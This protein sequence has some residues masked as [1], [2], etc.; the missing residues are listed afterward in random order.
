MVWQERLW[1]MKCWLPPF[2]KTSAVACRIVMASEADALWPRRPPPL[3]REEKEAPVCHKNDEEG[4]WEAFLRLVVWWFQ[5][6]TNYGYNYWYTELE[7]AEV[8]CEWCMQESFLKFLRACEAVRVYKRKNGRISEISKKISI[9]SFYQ[10]VPNFFQ[11]SWL[12]QGPPS[13]TL[14]ASSRGLRGS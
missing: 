7:I 3:R 6:R 13:I 4:R 1:A 5:W 12:T 2:Q 14:L 9:R 10:Y 8:F 11:N